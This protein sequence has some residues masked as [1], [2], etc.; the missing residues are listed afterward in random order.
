[1]NTL[2]KEKQIVAIAAPAEMRPERFK[3]PL[4]RA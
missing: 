1:M 4:R 3:F 2:A